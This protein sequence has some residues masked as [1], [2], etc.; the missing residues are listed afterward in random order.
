MTTTTKS[1]NKKPTSQC[2]EYSTEIK[3]ISAILDNHAEVIDELADVVDNHAEVL[4]QIRE[5]EDVL[6]SRLTI[7]FWFCG[8]TTAVATAL[9]I[10]SLVC[11]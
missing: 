11:K 7:I 2:N 1:K 9:A 4:G 3:T 10:T 6:A 5:N 8:I